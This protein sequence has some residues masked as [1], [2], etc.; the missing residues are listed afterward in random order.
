MSWPHRKSGAVEGSG[1]PA[2]CSRGERHGSGIRPGQGLLVLHVHH[3]WY[4][5][6]R[7]LAAARLRDAD[8]VL[9]LQAQGDRLGLDR[10]R[11]L[12]AVVAAGLQEPL[13]QHAAERPEA[14]QWHGS[15]ACGIVRH[16]DAQRRPPGLRGRSVHHAAPQEAPL[17]CDPVGPPRPVD[18]LQLRRLL[19]GLRGRP[20]WAPRGLR[21]GA[22][23]V[24]RGLG[25][26]REGRQGGAGAV[27]GAEDGGLRLSGHTRGG[28]HLVA[29]ELGSTLMGPLQD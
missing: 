15:G 14:L 12:P 8:E 20:P 25:G 22:S 21:P 29:D 24:G 27:S 7:R 13:R 6:R 2:V 5:E 1:R 18:G 9:A 19:P 23:C 4:Q 28:G 11:R 10:R 17:E 16:R 26:G 3:G